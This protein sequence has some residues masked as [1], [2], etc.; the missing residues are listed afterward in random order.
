[1]NIL[2]V[3]SMYFNFPGLI[4]HGSYGLHMFFIF[5]YFE[6][7]ILTHTHGGAGGGPVGLIYS[8]IYCI[9]VCS[10]HSASRCL[11]DNPRHV[12]NSDTSCG[13]QLGFL[14][15]DGIFLSPLEK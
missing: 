3:G 9:H 12:F 8:Y 7:L 13:M 5:R 6:I 10:I 2:Q 14:M 4:M 11:D 15:Q 1:M